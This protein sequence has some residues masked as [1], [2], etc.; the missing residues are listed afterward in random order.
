YA[1]YED[2]PPPCDAPHLTPCADPPGITGQ[3]LGSSFV[4]GIPYELIKLERVAEV[5]RAKLAGLKG[6]EF[7]AQRRAWRA[8]DDAFHSAVAAYAAR[9]DVAASPQE[10]EQTVRDVARRADEDPAIE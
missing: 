3:P 6:A 9:R 5:E 4:A 7:E 8:A 10:V 2:D 1:Q